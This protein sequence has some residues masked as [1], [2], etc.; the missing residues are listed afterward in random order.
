MKYIKLFEGYKHLAF[1]HDQVNIKDVKV[2]DYYKYQDKTIDER[3]EILEYIVKVTKTYEVDESIRFTGHED[4]VQF[5]AICIWPDDLR[6]FEMVS[7]DRVK[8]F[9]KATPEDIE[10]YKFLE[11]SNKYNL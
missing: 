10:E 3:E 11:E 6:G 9:N 5:K 8:Y 2:G 1:E 7:N 4:V